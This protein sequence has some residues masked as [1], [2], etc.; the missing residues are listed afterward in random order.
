MEAIKKQYV[1]DENDRRIAVQ[2]DLETFAKIERF[3]EDHALAKAITEAEDD[4]VLELDAA[5]AFY[6]KLAKAP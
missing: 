4:E 1:V 6:S 2:L 3:I 5:K